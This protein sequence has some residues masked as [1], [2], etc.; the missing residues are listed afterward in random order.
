MKPDVFA[1]L[2]P[3]PAKVKAVVTTEDYMTFTI[4]VNEYLCESSRRKALM[5]E[6]RHIYENH[7]TNEFIPIAQLEQLAS[8][9]KLKNKIG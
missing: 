8:E 1:W 7:F 6:L 4:F 5:H 3:L 9:I 2:V